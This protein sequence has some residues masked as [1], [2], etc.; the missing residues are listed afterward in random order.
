MSKENREQVAGILNEETTMFPSFD[1]DWCTRTTLVGVGSKDVFNTIYN[2]WLRRR[3]NV[4]AYN[5]RVALAN[6][7]DEISVIL[8]MI[9]GISAPYRP[10]HARPANQVL[11]ALSRYFNVVRVRRDGLLDWVWWG[12]RRGGGA[13]DGRRIKEMGARHR[14]LMEENTRL[15][16][17]GD[18]MQRQVMIGE[19]QRMAMTQRMIMMEQ[20]QRVM[21][22]QMM[23]MKQ[24]MEMMAR[25]R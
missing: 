18:E 8:P 25:R 4:R 13:G 7:V 24:R 16:E 15:G 17:R 10:T 9:H 12:G 22:Q 20:Q 2:G 6:G 11:Y 21:Y 1:G 19:Q 23:A 3:F 14:M 5:F